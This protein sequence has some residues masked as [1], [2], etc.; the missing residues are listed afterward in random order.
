MI[1][2]GFQCVVSEE[3]EKAKKEGEQIVKDRRTELQGHDWQ[4][5]KS[6]YH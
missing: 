5:Q 6:K 1:G 3:G 4:A 2:H